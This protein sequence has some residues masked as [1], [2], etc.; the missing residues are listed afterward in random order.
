[1]T[2]KPLHRFAFLGALFFLFSF[3]AG[4]GGET[5]AGSCTPGEV[6]SC[7]CLPSGDESVRTCAADGEF[8]SCDCD[9]VPDAGIPDDA[10]TVEPDADTGEPSVGNEC[11]GEEELFFDGAPASPTDRCGA[12]EDGVL[13]CDSPNSLRCIQTG[14]ADDC[15]SCEDAADLIGEACGACGDGAFECSD[16]DTVECVG[17]S[18][19]NACGG[20][21]SLL[22]SPGSDCGNGAVW[23]CD[24]LDDVVCD[25]DLQNNACGGTDTL[26]D[27]PGD[28]CG[29]CEDGEFVCVAPNATACAGASATNDCGGCDALPATPGDSCDEDSQWQCDG[30]SDVECIFV[31]DTNV[32]GGTAE[33]EEQPGEECGDC[34]V[35][36]C[37]G[38]DAV[39]CEGE[40][41]LQSDPDHCGS[42]SNQCATDHHCE[43]GSCEPNNACG[44]MAELDEQPGEECGDCGVWACQGDDAVICEDE[45]DLQSDPDNCGSCNHSCGDAE[46]CESGVCSIDEIVAVDISLDLG[47]AIRQSG[48]VFCWGDDA[49]GAFPMEPTDLGISDA[50][51]IAVGS[52]HACALLEDQQVVCWG[53]NDQGQLGDGS[54]TLYSS[55]PVFVQDLSNVSAITIGREHTC[56]ISEGQAYCWGDNTSG[57]LGDGSVTERNSPVAVSSELPDDVTVINAGWNFTCAIA[58]EEA[59]CWGMAGNGQLGNDSGFATHYSTPQKVVDL[60]AVRDIV[61]GQSHSC[62]ITTGDLAYCWGSNG[63]GRLGDGTTIQRETPVAVMNLGPVEKISVGTSASTCALHTDGQVYCWGLG[64]DG[65]LGTGSDENH[66]LP[67]W[68]STL[69]DEEA[70]VQL[71]SGRLSRCVLLANGQLACWGR[72]RFGILKDNQSENDWINTHYPR[73]LPVISPL[74][75]PVTSEYG[76][77]FSDTDVSG[78]GLVDCEDPD[79]ATDLGEATG[80]DVTSGQLIGFAGH[81]ANGSCG[82][83]GPENVYTW[84]APMSG[85]FTF[86]AGDQWSTDPDIILYLRESCTADEL[87][88]TTDGGPDDRPSLQVQA[89]AGETYYLFVDSEPSGTPGTSFPDDGIYTVHIHPPN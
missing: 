7:L 23:S 25:E 61:A 72:N 56:A 34:G 78:N 76:Q 29:P 55:S 4:C 74:V 73:W 87:A 2:Y 8:G 60:G 10:S 5:E 53:A 45:V 37:E 32:C 11:G 80:N 43:A 47:C 52:E 1:M 39:T 3:L 70:V 20:C 40:V 62:A 21:Q 6:E 54:T 13:A 75:A 84:T 48:E 64:G 15:G 28:H 24:G 27:M 82:G 77:C 30:D 36:V 41:D 85:A 35:W 81:Y 12:C 31:G 16:D 89:T 38:D 42:C 46:N 63:Q 88:C 49:A 79:C 65:A 19:A 69:D 83:T 44:G 86:E 58:D 22:H 59:Y 26:G 14:E 67:Q 33:L 9:A 57:K 17:A 18:S 51:A 71:V 66:N 68:V 50:T